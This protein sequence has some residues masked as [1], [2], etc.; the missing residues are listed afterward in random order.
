M[1]HILEGLKN[2]C[3]RLAYLMSVLD[4]TILTSVAGQ[5]NQFVAGAVGVAVIFGIAVIY[6]A[7]SPKDKERD[8][9][10]L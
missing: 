10:K 7:L 8:F 1:Y 5:D 6:Y 4:S 9:P 3:L 2:R